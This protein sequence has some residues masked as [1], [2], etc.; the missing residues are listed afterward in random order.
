MF[1]FLIGL[2]G[3]LTALIGWFSYKSVT[4]LFVGTVLYL[5][6][7]LLEWKEL[8]ANAKKL[9]VILFVIGSIVALFIGQPFYIGGM[10]V[11]NFHSAIMILISLPL[12]IKQI[13]MFIA[14]L[15]RK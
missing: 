14:F 13:T 7:T 1:S 5:V 11:L 6:E 15:F 4:L 12:I 10:L 3:V 2:I 9:D 8:N